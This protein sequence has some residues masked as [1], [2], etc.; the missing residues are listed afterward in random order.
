MSR[1]L[2]RIIIV[3]RAITT[4]DMSKANTS[5]HKYELALAQSLARYTTVTVL[6]LAASA[7]EGKVIGQLKLI[8]LKA[9]NKHFSPT[10]AHALQQYQNENA[11]VLFWGFDPKLIGPILSSVHG[12]SLKCIAF[13]YDSFK[14]YVNALPQPKRLLCDLYLRMGMAMVRHCNGFILFQEKAV[15]RLRINQKKYLVCK[16]GFKAKQ[17]NRDTSKDRFVVVYSGSFTKLNGINSLLGAFDLLQNE[18]IEF[19]LC[20]DGPMEK[21]VAE[22][23]EKFSFVHYMGLLKQAELDRVYEEADVLLNLRVMNDEAMDFSFPSKLFEYI[24]MQIPIITTRTLP[25]TEFAENATIVDALDA[26]HIAE[27]VLSVRGN[28]AKAELKARHLFDYIQ[29]TYSNE[30]MTRQI[31]CFMKE[32]VQ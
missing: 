9:A 23:T 30:E 27:A 21:E 32:I 6:S 20:G 19:I 7:D 13:E 18:G 14:P 5:S 26:Q 12:M 31:Y 10:L 24:S 29:S 8:G 16:P 28:Y 15:T 25:E 1:Q 3:T 2:D 11:V 17:I 22:A 4:L